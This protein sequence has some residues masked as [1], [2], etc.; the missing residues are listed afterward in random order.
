[1]IRRFLILVAILVLLGIPMSAVI[2]AMDHLD[3]QQRQNKTLGTALS[4]CGLNEN[5][6]VTEG[7]K[8]YNKRGL[9]VKGGN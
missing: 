4:K 9:R 1:M 7:G 8:C 3:I 2:G 5:G 6:H